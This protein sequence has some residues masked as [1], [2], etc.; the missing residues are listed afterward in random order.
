MLKALLPHSSVSMLLLLVQLLLTPAS[1]H[2]HFP[3]HRNLKGLEPIQSES[4]THS[5]ELNDQDNDISLDYEGQHHPDLLN[6]LT[7]QEVARVHCSSDD[8]TLTVTLNN[9]IDDFHR[10]WEA[11]VGHPLTAVCSNT[12]TTKVVYRQV[13][14]VQQ[15]GD[16]CLRITCSKLELHQMFSSLHLKMS[17]T[18]S[19]PPPPPPS[20]PQ[21]LRRRLLS[22]RTTQV[23][24]D[25]AS[26][27]DVASFV[28]GVRSISDACTLKRRRL[29]FMKKVFSKWKSSAKSSWDDVSTSFRD[30]FQSVDTSGKNRLECAIGPN[31]EI[32]YNSETKTHDKDV[33]EFTPWATCHNCYFWAG[34]KVVVEMDVSATGLTSFV[35]YVEGGME[36]RAK[37]VINNPIDTSGGSG[38]FNVIIPPSSLG[39][40][41]FAVGSVPVKINVQSG[42][43]MS[44]TSTGTVNTTFTAGASMYALWREGVQY[45]NGNW[46]N[47]IKKDVGFDYMLPQ[48][49]MTPS[50]AKVTVHMR[51]VIELLVWETALIVN[52]FSST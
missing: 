24:R 13:E 39:T 47:I 42:L 20:P 10:R 27:A 52:V 51:P 7:H 9:P 1:G 46:E 33:L 29:G 26:P 4:F 36:A 32:N 2:R 12:P 40:L 30:E 37:A 8:T 21:H 50:N 48:W 3:V 19:T 45:K 5:F 23:A 22:E 41:S 38:E 16:K 34:I 14:Q 31:I 43:E 17:Y 25:L 18:P 28:S 11:R 6:L 15:C 35:S 49:S 44:G